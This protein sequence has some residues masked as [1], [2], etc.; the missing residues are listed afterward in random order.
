MSLMPK[1]GNFCVPFRKAEYNPL[2]R[3]SHEEFILV[4]K[5]LRKHFNINRLYKNRVS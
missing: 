5:K 3:I 1:V 2:T 4:M